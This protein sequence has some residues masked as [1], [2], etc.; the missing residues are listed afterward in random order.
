MNLSMCKAVKYMCA[1]V[2]TLLV[3]LSTH[4]RPRKFSMAA[5]L[6]LIQFQMNDIVLGR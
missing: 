6:P 3:G 4:P 2:A 1:K 5:K